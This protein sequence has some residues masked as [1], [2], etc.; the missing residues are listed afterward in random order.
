[1][2]KHTPQPPPPRKVFIATRKEGEQKDKAFQKLHETFDTTPQ[3][4]EAAEFIV[5]DLE[6]P[7]E[8]VEWA[9]AL[10]FADSSFLAEHCSPPIILAQIGEV[11]KNFKDVI[12]PALIRGA[13][14]LPTYNTCDEILD[15]L[16]RVERAVPFYNKKNLPE[17]QGIE[18]ARQEIAETAVSLQ[19]LGTKLPR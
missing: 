17:Q 18:Q 14:K 8:P 16:C 15:W 10:T 1:M 7:L 9:D 5:V 4:A 6:D 2:K 13:S 19:R 3:T 11:N 12:L